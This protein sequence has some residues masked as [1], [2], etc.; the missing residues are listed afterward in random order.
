MRDALIVVHALAGV[1]A[2]LLGIRLVL[3]ARVAREPTWFGGYFA[4][5][6]VL[7]LT[8]VPATALDWPDLDA[9]T[10][11]AYA[12]LACL[13]AFM[14]WRADRAR[15]IAAERSEDSRRTFIDHVGFTLVSLLAGFVIVLAVDLSGQAWVVTS[16]GVVGV[17]VG[18]Q[19]VEAA[20]KRIT[21]IT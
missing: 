17:L 4:S 3:A 10:R 9:G 15:R 16:V 5:M 7:L 13:A 6:V 14:V 2:F 20:K 21:P 19:S 12:A 11:V 1:T 8:L 18:R